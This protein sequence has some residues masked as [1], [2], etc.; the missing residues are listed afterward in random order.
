MENVQS[1][2]SGTKQFVLQG[3]F[4]TVVYCFLM[5]LGVPQNV[6]GLICIVGGF[7][8]FFITNIVRQLMQE[9]LAAAQADEDD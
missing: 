3:V 2:S 4:L 6:T 5:F 1:K 9:K 8:L 7:L